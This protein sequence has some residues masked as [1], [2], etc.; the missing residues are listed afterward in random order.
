MYGVTT[1]VYVLNRQDLNS[2]FPFNIFIDT[3]KGQFDF[4]LSGA[5]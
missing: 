5:V 1:E 2:Y 3:F 4:H